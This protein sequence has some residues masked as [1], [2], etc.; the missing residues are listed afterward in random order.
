MSSVAWFRF[1]S[2][3]EKKLWLIC[4]LINWGYAIKAGFFSPFDSFSSHYSTH[5][6]FS[7]GS[8]SSVKNISISNN[9]AIV[10]CFSLCLLVNHSS[11]EQCR[12]LRSRRLRV[13]VNHIFIQCFH[14]SKAKLALYWVIQIHICWVLAAFILH[15]NPRWSLIKKSCWNWCLKRNQWEDYTDP[16]MHGSSGPSH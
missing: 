6:S 5:C 12:I 15:E 7:R 8:T 14:S 9:F 3:I 1:P 11:F 13:I 4:V 2:N 10:Y 16:A